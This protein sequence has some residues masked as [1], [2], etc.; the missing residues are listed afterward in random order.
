MTDK[1][2]VIRHT[3]NWVSQ[4]V[5]G[6]NFCPF[7]AKEVRRGSIHYDTIETDDVEKSLELVAQAFA[8]LDKNEQIETTLL[9]FPE[10]L[11]DFNDYLHF[12]EL[13]ES[14]LEEMNYEG[15]YQVA[16]FHPNYLFQGSDQDDPA[17]YTNRSPYPMLHLLRESS[18]SAAIDSFPDVDGIPERNIELARKKGLAQM[19]ALWAACF[20]NTKD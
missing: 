2:E 18:L 4:I 9:I 5:V 13:T 15:V 20:S 11:Q 1:E 17:N 19:K 8:Q 14:L 6:L 7:A 10:S 16:S 12:V 3:M